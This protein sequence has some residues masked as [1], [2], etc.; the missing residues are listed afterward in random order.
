MQI[1][2]LTI[3]FHLVLFFYFIGLGSNLSSLSPY[4]LTY[5]PNEAEIIFQFTMPLGSFF[6]GWISDYTKQLRWLLFWD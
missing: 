3:L 2:N 5:F 6:G 1:T 4:I